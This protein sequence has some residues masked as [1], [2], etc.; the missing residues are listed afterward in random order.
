M[1]F[2]RST[3]LLISFVFLAF[4]ARSQNCTQPTEPWSPLGPVPI[5]KG[6]V[7]Y[8]GIL[9]SCEHPANDTLLQRFYVGSN[10]SG[11]YYT[12][13]SNYW[14]NLTESFKRPGLGIQD[15]ALHE[16]NPG[17]ILLATGMSTYGK[18]YGQGLIY[19]FNHGLTWAQVKEINPGEFTNKIA[20][21]CMFLSGS[22]GA[23]A[24][25][26]DELWFTED[27]RKEN[28]WE[29]V[30]KAKPKSKAVGKYYIDEIKFHPRFPSTPIIY[31]A[32]SDPIVDDG[33]SKI[34]RINIQE[35]F[36]VR[37][38]K[39]EGVKPSP[40]I[41]IAV[42]PEKPDRLYCILNRPNSRFELYVSEDRGDS[43]TKRR[44]LNAYGMGM[45]GFEMEV[46]PTDPEVIYYGGI[47][48]YRQVGIDKGTPQRIQRNIHDDTRDFLVLKGSEKGYNSQNDV[49]LNANDGGL[50]IN[51]GGA[52]EDWNSLNGT[53]VFGLN[54][55]QFYGIAIHPMDTNIIAGGLQ[56]N[57]TI[58]W[59]RDSLAN[60]IYGG[61]GGDVAYTNDGALLA[62][63]NGG[64]RPGK[65]FVHK[66]GNS[67]SF[68]KTSFGVSNSP[69]LIKRDG[70]ALYAH[71]QAGSPPI[72]DLVE[73]DMN[74]GEIRNLSQKGDRAIAA[75]GVA[76]SDEETI[77]Y[78][79]INV[80]YGPEASETVW[81]STDGGESWN[82]ISKGLGGSK[83]HRVSAIAVHPADP[84]RLIV[85]YHGNSKPAHV[86]LSTNGG[87]SWE[88]I[89][90]G[91]PSYGT[92]RLKYSKH[93]VAFSATDLGMYV[94]DEALKEWTCFSAGLPSLPISD[95]EFDYCKNRI[96]ASSFGRGL[97]EAEY[98]F[99]AKRNLI[100]AVTFDKDT[101]IDGST[102][103]HSDILLEK[104]VKLEIK[105]TERNQTKV[106]LDEGLNIK[107]KK[108]AELVLSNAELIS[109]CST[110]WS[111]MYNFGFLSKK[112]KA[113]FKQNGTSKVINLKQS[114]FEFKA[115]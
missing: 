36:S 95:F 24:G 47:S 94:F 87:G 86:Y 96:V 71:A 44:K 46:S 111:L 3:F 92:N 20:R 30:W 84:E 100:P 102:S 48:L 83:Y 97:W 115:E 59:H 4:Q 41:D 50:S 78:A 66:N 69:L 58:V 49:L 23:I 1:S 89:S 76:A 65:L 61:D 35:N 13:G 98:P 62:N 2:T 77:Y 37:P 5:K 51:K 28:A 45:A 79:N 82:D 19:T 7:P 16:E 80:S 54:I 93:G 73:L 21:R 90:K 10:S 114:D 60:H 88:L 26:E 15:I 38:L 56:D 25:V 110:G 72:F 99:Q 22:Y 32:M 9:V 57:G 106:Y 42:S 12:E 55:S 52:R 75:I 29:M 67:K 107:L 103:F 8:Q 43:W 101:V 40:R 108:G 39:I 33:G 17:L 81:R 34:Y 104:N 70:K 53:G 64:A 63:F 68:P 109:N 27:I 18:D 112:V 113:Q 85:S 14:T 74:S 6:K 105:G 11:L 91:L 31:V